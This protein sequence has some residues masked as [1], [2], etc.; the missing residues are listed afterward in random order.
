MWILKVF[1]YSTEFFY[2]KKKS[3]S[4]ILLLILS[5]TYLKY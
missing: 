5:K 1:Q 2:G 4:Y 3:N